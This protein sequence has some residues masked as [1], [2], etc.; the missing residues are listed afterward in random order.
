MPEGDEYRRIAAEC[1]LVASTTA[2]PDVRAELHALAHANLRLAQQAE[3]NS[4]TDLVYEVPPQSQR[5]RSPE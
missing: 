4:R 3:R 5:S 1:L 2:D